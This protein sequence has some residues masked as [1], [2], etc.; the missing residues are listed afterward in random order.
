MLIW[1]HTSLKRGGYDQLILSW[2]QSSFIITSRLEISRSAIQF[3][4]VKVLIWR[5]RSLYLKIIWHCERGQVWTVVHVV[6]SSAAFEVAFQ[7][8]VECGC[9]S[10]EQKTNK[11]GFTAYSFALT[12]CII[13]YILQSTSWRKNTYYNFFVCCK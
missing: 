11:T 13:S 1:C 7:S 2:H 3:L 4:M 6:V 9:F 5:C 12:Y 10:Y 8:F